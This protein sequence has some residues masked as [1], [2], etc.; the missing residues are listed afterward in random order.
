MQV[1]DKLDKQDSKLDKQ[2]SKLDQQDSKLDFNFGKHDIKLDL[3]LG[4]VTKS[5]IQKPGSKHAMIP[6]E[7]PELP[8]T[9]QTRPA[10]IAE[11]KERVLGQAVGT[12]AVVG[13]SRGAAATTS[14]HGMGGVGKTTAAAYLVRDPEVGAAFESLL[15]VCVS[16][17]PDILYLLSRLYSQ[18]KSAKL[19][20]WVEG[21]LDA[22]Q[23]LRQAAKG[24]RALLILDDCW[25]E[26]H[27][28]LLN[29][30]DA[31]T[32]SACVIT[33]RVRNL[34]SREIACGLLSVKE[35]LTLMLSS[36]GLE[37]LLDNPPAAALEAVECCGRLPLALPI[38]G[39]M[40]RELEEVWEAELIPMLKTELSNELSVETR[41]VN[42]S[43]RCVEQSQRAGVGVLFTCFG[44]FTEDAVVPAAALELLAPI[45]S[46]RV[47]VVSLSPHIK[48]QKWL[49][50]LLRASLLSGSGA[51][52][53]S[54]HDLVRDVMM[55]RA[56]AEAGGMVGLQREVLRAFIAAY[57]HDSSE[58]GG[59]GPLK[60]FIVRSIHHHVNYSQQPGVPLHEDE[61]LMT[62]LSHTSSVISSRSAAGIGFEQ[63]QKAIDLCEGGGCWWEAA[64]LWAAVSTLRGNRAAGAELKRAWAAIRHVQPE[65]GQSRALEARVLGLLVSVMQGGYTWGSPEHTGVSD[66]LTAL[67]QL[68]LEDASTCGKKI[69]DSAKFDALF[70][71]AMSQQMKAHISYGLFSYVPVSPKV[72]SESY[73][74]YVEASLKWERAVLVAPDLLKRSLAENSASCYSRFS[75]MHSLPEFDKE[76]FTGQG[77]SMMRSNIKVYDFT[78][79][80]SPLKISSSGM[81][82][83]LWGHNET[84]LLLW[85]GDLKTARTCWLKQVAAWK[86][87]AVLVQSGKYKWGEYL[88]ETIAMRGARYPI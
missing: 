11:M 17:G 66:R 41:I 83:F 69:L 20:A 16:E 62:V 28:E 34:A 50:S 31:E 53:V 75:R 18:L 58:A 6:P 76:V 65:T 23:E 10:L 85:F 33:T 5:E 55:M 87:I 30:V 70:A 22:L 19:P 7:V 3:I 88:A 37:H 36:A 74:E 49:T 84:G 39:S 57:C 4:I 73:I 56:E 15:W 42:A 13:V 68:A 60:D 52:G 64:Q 77:G 45:I 8:F 43:L 24:V 12:I 82:P 81:D 47:A 38:A 79:M 26:K 48:V 78:G 27:V 72:L 54:V 2:D 63:L 71:D 46:Q 51:Y 21:E 9:L 25:E 32:G 29:C 80:H 1:N 35:S 61:L 14:A 59:D 40:I 44:C 67:G 86:Q